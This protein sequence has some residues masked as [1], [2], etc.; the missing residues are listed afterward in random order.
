[1]EN[2]ELVR[3]P[4]GTEVLPGTTTDHVFE[5]GRSLGLVCRDE[6][7]PESRL[8]AADEIWLTGATKGVAP[9]VRLND[10]SVGTGSPGPIW[11]KLIAHFKI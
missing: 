9:V 5:V 8:F 11:K 2:G 7:I 4:Q 10:Q 6:I 3:R 1:V